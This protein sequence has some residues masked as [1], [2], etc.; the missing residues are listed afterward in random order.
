MPRRL[1]AISGGGRRG[2]RRR[3]GCH[4]KVPTRAS[5]G[6]RVGRLWFARARRYDQRERWSGGAVVAAAPGEVWCA[7]AGGR[8]PHVWRTGSWYGLPNAGRRGGCPVRRPASLVGEMA[9]VF[10]PQVGRG[11][12][13]ETLVGQMPCSVRQVAG[14]RSPARVRGGMLVR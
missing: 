13:V 11:Q 4:Q 2:L 5:A 6:A 3:V 1:K 8:G 9:L 12:V 14:R 10:V 7:A